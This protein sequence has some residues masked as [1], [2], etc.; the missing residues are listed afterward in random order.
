VVATEKNSGSVLFLLATSCRCFIAST[1]LS[2]PSSRV[3]LRTG[4][5]GRQ[6]VS[7]FLPC[8][9][10][11]PEGP[12][13]R[14]GNDRSTAPCRNSSDDHSLGAL[15]HGCRLSTRVHCMVS[16]ER[17]RCRLLLKRVAMARGCSWV[18]QSSWAIAGGSRPEDGWGSDAHS[19][20]FQCF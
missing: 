4:P 12:I 13:L 18:C 9:P 11:T 3:M 19:G 1:A 7:P 5:A 10:R 16:V 14:G 15:R 17:R 2:G 6:V 8:F 20:E